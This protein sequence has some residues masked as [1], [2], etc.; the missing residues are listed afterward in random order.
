MVRSVEA[1][2]PSGDAGERHPG[3][4]ERRSSRTFESFLRESDEMRGLPGRSILT[5]SGVICP[6]CEGFHPPGTQFCPGESSNREA[7]EEE[8]SELYGKNPGFM[9]PDF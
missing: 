9:V 7:L 3:E 8:R 6:H 1:T 2:V 5:P 4:Q